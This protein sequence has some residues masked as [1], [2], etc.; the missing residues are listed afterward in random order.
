MK[1]VLALTLVLLCFL[2]GPVRAGAD[3]NFRG[4]VPAVPAWESLPAEPAA[5]AAALRRAVETVLAAEA[6]Q[7]SAASD[8]AAFSQ[9]WLEILN[10]SFGYKLIYAETAGMGTVALAAGATA[11]RD[12]THYFL[13]DRTLC[14]AAEPCDAEIIIDPTYMQFL[15]Q[16]ECLY[17]ETEGCAGAEV[18]RG[19][20]RVLMGTRA[21]IKAFYSAF[22]ERVRLYSAGV[23]DLPDGSYDPASAASL[24][25]SFE[26]NSGLRSN[27]ELLLPAR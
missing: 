1:I 5:R 2:A 12:K 10:G 13:V 11:R 19:L 16:G 3:G 23:P 7:L 6:G 20:P 24:I 17:G 25:Y 9:I 14:G 26:F 8:C 15:E 22:P 18:L 21:E 27:I 4:A